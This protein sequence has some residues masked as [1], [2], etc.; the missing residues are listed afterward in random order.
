MMAQYLRIKEDHRDAVLFF[1][2]GDFYE[3]F[4]QD[5][6]E[7]SRL[8]NLTLTQRAGNPMCGIPYH[9]SRVYIARLLR[10][11]KK[12]AICEQ[13]TIPGPGKGIAE[14]KVVEIITPG[15]AVEEEYLEQNVNNY[16]ASFYVSPDGVCAYSYIDVTTGEFAGTVFSGPDSP[17]RFR[18]ELGRIQPREILVPQSLGDSYPILAEALADQSSML[19]NRYPEWSY[20][21]QSA[22]KRLC[23]AF[24]TASL[25]SFGLTEASPLVA[26]AALVIEYLNQTAGAALSHVSGITVYGETDFLSIDDSTRKNLELVQNLRD[27]SSSYTLYEVLNQTRTAMGARLLR[28]WIHHPLT[29]RSAIEERNSLVDYLYRSQRLLARLRDH[30]STVLDIERLAA[31]VSMERAHGKDLVALKQSL[32]AFL[33]IQQI[34]SSDAPASF[35]MEA[36]VADSI[37]QLK[38]LLSSSLK[39]DCSILLTE[40]NLIKDGW[41]PRL[42]ELRAL[43]DNSQAVLDAYVAEE[44]DNTGIQNLKIRYNRL[45]G[46]YL[47][48]SKGNLHAVPSHFIRRRSLSNGERFTTDRLVELETE[49]NGVHANITELEQQLF[50]EIRARVGADLE[51]LSYAA[52]RISRLDALQSFAHAATL[53][54]WTKPA[55]SDSGVMDIRGGRHPVVELHLP[56][57]SFVPNGI[58]LDSAA[59]SDAPSFALITGPNMAGKSTFLRQTA[60]I[61][62]MA[63]LGSFVPAESVVLTPVD[64]IFCRVGASDNL[65][66]GESTFLVEMTET[67]HILRTATKSS[68]VIMDEVGRGTSTE[69]GLAIARSVT[70]YLLHSIGAKTLFATHYHELSHLQF[71]RLAH[72][73]LDVL[74]SEGTV[75]FLKKLRSG[76]SA[77]SYGIHVARLAGIPDQVLEAAKKYVKLR[78]NDFPE[79]SA[80]SSVPDAAI[81][82]KSK[83]I[84]FG[85]SLFPEEE[86]ILNELLSISIESLTPL[87]ALTYLDG[88]KRKLSGS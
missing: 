41:S 34:F 59:E 6:I 20:N 72:F 13:L 71:P 3:M 1:R 31:R 67:A 9:A 75:V 85:P 7:V 88:W 55:F 22:Y 43:R 79:A 12:I 33:K 77:N 82:A 58:T 27:G 8:L 37:L 65:A 48:V 60:L 83:P 40:G 68:L 84:S 35:R 49:L 47:E 21:L 29:D 80:L 32:E 14:R 46:Y 56:S 62:L 87:Q 30:L 19:I 24:R 16:L 11:G 42:D 76:A 54:A 45:I 26:S 38:D 66:R 17:E 23:G 36:A 25:Q 73:C 81:E 18:K 69:D 61:T 15:T 64:R 2:L 4:H 86:L 10:A 78:E 74:E 44:R 51:T 50:L 39:E 63:Q 53:Y 70:E 52:K 28:A 5:A 57:G